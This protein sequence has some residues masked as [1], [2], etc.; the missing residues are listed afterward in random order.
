MD[1]SKSS[2][3]QNEEKAP[4]SDSEVSVNRENRGSLRSLGLLIILGLTPILIYTALPN[5]SH[6]EVPVENALRRGKVK[7]V[8]TESIDGNETEI[9]IIDLILKRSMNA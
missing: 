7:V 8:L 5:K 1:D 2:S 9:N 6:E 4:R 3:D